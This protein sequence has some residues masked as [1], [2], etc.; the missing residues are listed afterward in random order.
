MSKEETKETLE[1]G[2]DTKEMLAA[3]GKKKTKI[4]Y[5]ERKTIIMTK[6][7]RYHREGDILS[8][9]KVVANEYIAK[10]IAKPYTAKKE[11]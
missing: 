7:T 3:H 5:G 1:L 9:Q 10:K 8:P 2:V 6:N 11:D 4:K